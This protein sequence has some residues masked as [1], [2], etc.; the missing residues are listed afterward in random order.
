MPEGDSLH[1]AARKL[2]VLV[3]E[4]VAVETPHPRAAAERVAERLDG[5]RLE[6]VQAVGKNLLLTF[7]GGLVLR[8]H[9]RMTG[10]WQVLDRGAPRHGKPWLVLAGQE[11]EAVLWNGPVLALSSRGTRRLGPDI[12][13]EPPDLAG[14][15]ANLRR[16]H[17]GRELGEA[18][19][20]QR[21]VAGIGNIWKAESLWHARLSPW[22]RLGDVTDEELKRVLREAARLMRASVDS[23]NDKRAAYKR[24]GRPCPRCGEPIRSRGQGDDNRTAYWCEG[25]QRGEGSPGA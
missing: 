14:M 9:L 3:G 8:S 12:L 19:L 6:A 7:E 1:R 11:R 16:E 22:L 24:A 25:C 23:W 20:D 13:A 4:R 15:I 21:L 5:R 18:L 17:P 2:Q 10:R